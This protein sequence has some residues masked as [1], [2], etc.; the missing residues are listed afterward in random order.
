MTVAKKKLGKITIII[1][2]P[3][4]AIGLWYFI[5]HTPSRAP[6]VKVNLEGRVIDKIVHSSTW[7]PIDFSLTV[8]EEELLKRCLT[9]AALMRH[10]Q[11]QIPL[12]KNE[13]VKTE[14]ESIL[15][16]KP[17]FFYAEYLL[18]LWYEMNDENSK[19]RQFYDQALEHAPV[20]LEQGYENEFGQAI[21]GANIQSLSIEHNRVNEKGLDPSLK[22]QFFNLTTDIKGVIKIPVYDTVYRI[23]SIAHPTGYSAE[24]ASLGWFEKGGYV[25]VLPVAH[26]TVKK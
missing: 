11:N 14:L 5:D 10:S 4:I 2:L 15:K 1:V 13:E 17:N 25:G 23:S 7:R 6:V 22:L 8:K 18:G 19:S 24:Y 21:Q 9:Q 3:L 20:V 12:F 26:L 16:E